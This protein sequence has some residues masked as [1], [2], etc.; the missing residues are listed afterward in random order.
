[1]ERAQI[2]A[3]LAGAQGGSYRRCLLLFDGNDAD[4]LADARAQWATLK[5]AGHD[6][7]YFQQGEDGRWQQKA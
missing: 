7:A 5:S 4:Q 6:L 1:M 2:T 3:A